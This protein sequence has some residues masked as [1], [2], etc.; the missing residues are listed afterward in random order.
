MSALVG[1]VVGTQVGS[2][3]GANPFLVP[4]VD[5]GSP[6]AESARGDTTLGPSV[7]SIPTT[8]AGVNALSGAT[9]TEWWVLT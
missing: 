9:F 2:L 3:T 1:T 6:G 7:Q 5:Y 4:L 8:V